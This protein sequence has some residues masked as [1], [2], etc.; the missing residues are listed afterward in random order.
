[1]ERTSSQVKRQKSVSA[2]LNN[3]RRWWSSAPA[4][5]VFSA[6]L[7]GGTP[8]H[9]EIVDWLYDVEVP[10][11]SQAQGDQ[12]DAA[13]TALREMLTRMTGL[14]NVPMSQPI[15]RALN[16]P[17]LYYVQYRFI[18]AR[19]DGEQRLQVSFEPKAIQELV[20]DAAL[21]IWSADRPRILAW[22]AIRE[23]GRVRVL[24]SNSDHPL[25]ESVRQRSRQ[26][27]VPLQLP[28]L[29]LEDRELISPPAVWDGFAFS[30]HS[31]SRRY[32]AEVVLVGRAAPVDNG[33]WRT[34]WEFWLNGAPRQ[35]RYSD[36][37]VQ[38]GAVQAMDEVADDLMQRFAVFGLDAT[39]IE[40][41][42]R[43]A[44]S[45]RRYAALMRHLSNLEYIERVHLTAAA[46]ESLTLRITTRSSVER[47]GELLSKDGAFRRLPTLSDD[48]PVF[49][50]EGSEGGSGLPLTLQ[51]RGDG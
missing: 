15:V 14:R 3:G 36:A 35:L 41:A 40:I 23:D 37:D 4:A 1:M 28:L 11:R 39:D 2:W 18:Q 17:E 21:P 43:G 48:L 38:A 8:L 16:S 32:D 9:G 24:D 26:R 44:G 29:D 5:A 50:V 33:E 47:L 31:A 12:R 51:W 13:R 22:L 45:V 7:C 42:V 20:S 49:G 27:G 6:V 30:L 46:R 19:D 25:A 10:A 34:D